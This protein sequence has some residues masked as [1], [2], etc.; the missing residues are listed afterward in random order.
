[1]W[2]GSDVVGQFHD[3]AAYI[4]RIL[5]GAKPGEL[6]IARPSRLQLTVNLVLAARIGIAI[7]PAFVNRADEV[8]D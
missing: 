4:D 6:P 3:A 8:I 5:K 1:M 2:Y 7:N